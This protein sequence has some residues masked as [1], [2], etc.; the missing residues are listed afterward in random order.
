MT[1]AERVISY[2]EIEPEPGYENSTQPP[3]GWPQ[4][5]KVQMENLSLVYYSGGPPNHHQQAGNSPVK[6]SALFSTHLMK[7]HASHISGSIQT[8]RSRNI[9]GLWINSCTGRF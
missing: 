3:E 6:T 2:T 4:H 8:K 7:S 9:D 5:G 1:S